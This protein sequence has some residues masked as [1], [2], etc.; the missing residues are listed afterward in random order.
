MMHH[1]VSKLLAASTLALAVSLS[2]SGCDN[3]ASKSDKTSSVDEILLIAP[4]D[5]TTV[6]SNAFASG[7]SIT[8]TIQPEID[9]KVLQMRPDQAIELG[10][11]GRNLVLQQGQFL[12]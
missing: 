1:P 9:A 5:L 3:A 12:A 2:L 11:K 4:E 8:G 6:H 7:P 10:Q